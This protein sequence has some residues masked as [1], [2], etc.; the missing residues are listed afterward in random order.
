[1]QKISDKMRRYKQDKKKRRQSNANLKI[2][3]NKKTRH[4][5]LPMLQTRHNNRSILNDLPKR[6]IPLHHKINSEIQL[7]V[8]SWEVQTTALLPIHRKGHLAT[9]NRIRVIGDDGHVIPSTHELFMLARLASNVI[10]KDLHHVLFR[11]GGLGRGGAVA[12]CWDVE[13]LVA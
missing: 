9:A 12:V 3:Y 4:Q 7:P 10:L 8:A 6:P 2:K 5:S 11:V 13:G 1:M